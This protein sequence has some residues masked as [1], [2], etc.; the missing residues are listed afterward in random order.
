M[1][2]ILAR[3]AGSKISQAELSRA[4]KPPAPAEYEL[5]RAKLS[6]DA[7]LL[8]SFAMFFTKQKLI[9]PLS[10]LFYEMIYVLVAKRAPK[11]W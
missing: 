5:N 9:P 7:S 8:K 3:R 4:E 1:G 6:S 11:L 2:P 10:G